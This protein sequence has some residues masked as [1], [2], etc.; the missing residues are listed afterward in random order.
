MA[1][2]PPEMMS[3]T[4]D[5]HLHLG[6][7]LSNDTRK[8]R[9]MM[10][11]ELTVL[12]HFFEHITPRPNSQQREL[13]GLQLNMTP[14]TVQ[15]WFQ[16]RRAKVKK[17]GNGRPAS[18]D[19]NASSHAGRQ[20]QQ[21][22]QQQQGFPASMPLVPPQ[23]AL[24]GNMPPGMRVPLPTPPLSKHS[25]NFGTESGTAA[26]SPPPIAPRAIA[27]SPNLAQF[28]ASIPAHQPMLFGA[29]ADPRSGVLP[30][31]FNVNR[32]QQYS[33]NPYMAYAY[34]ASQQGQLNGMPQQ[35]GALFLQDASLVSNGLMPSPPLDAPAGFTHASPLSSTVSPGRATPG[36]FDEHKRYIFLGPTSP[37]GQKSSHSLSTTLAELQPQLPLM[38]GCET[39]AAVAI[40][41]GTFADAE[42]ATRAQPDEQ[43]QQ[44]SSQRQDQEVADFSVLSSQLSL[45]DFLN[46]SSGGDADAS[47]LDPG[48]QYLSLLPDMAQQMHLPAEFDGSSS[49]AARS[50]LGDVDPMLTSQTTKFGNGTLISKAAIS[51]SMEDLFASLATKYDLATTERQLSGS[52][53]SSF[54]LPLSTSSLDL[55]TNPGP[56]RSSTHS[57]LDLP[58][59][60][61]SSSDLFEHALPTSEFRASL[62][63]RRSGASD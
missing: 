1:H 63:R 3:Y 44:Q 6:Y 46:F 26:M 37:A 27:P 32:M 49:L 53:S 12:Q 41:F 31:S 20:Q 29:Q 50:P 15:V 4:D 43:E 48:G 58:D 16:N 59:F 36:P 17:E 18:V 24:M 38:S 10:P 35:A 2:L 13:L 14:R 5:S 7:A 56:P 57:P 9:R 25:M 11:E 23:S 60:G 33:H 30:L 34:G 22:Q 62:K 42:A 51:H 47:V 19:S 55:A 61:T 52:G 39:G 21:Q 28:A 40:P 45:E 8:R 54:A